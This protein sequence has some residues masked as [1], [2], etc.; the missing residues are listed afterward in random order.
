MKIKTQIQVMNNVT[1]AIDSVDVS[2]TCTSSI[3]FFIPSTN[4]VIELE[5]NRKE[6]YQFLVRTM[7]QFQFPAKVDAYEQANI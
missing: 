7:P 5:L 3:S 4:G 2:T 1:M 6:L